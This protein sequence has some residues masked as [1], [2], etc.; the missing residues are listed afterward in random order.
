MSKTLV[1]IHGM[2]GTGRYWSV[3]RALFEV[4]GFTCVAPTLPWHMP[5]EESRRQAVGVG[6]ASLGDYLTYLENCLDAL[7]LE[8]PPILVGH[9]MGGLLSMRLATR[10]PVAALVLLCPAP[11][12]GINAV[13]LDSVRAFLHCL[14]NG[15]FWRKPQRPG[16]ASAVRSTL[17]NLSP[18]KQR[19]YHGRMV[20]E[21][22]RALF[23]IAFPY[24]DSTQG[25]RV[26]RHRLQ[27][28]ILL[29]GGGQDRIVPASVQ[30]R[31]AAW[32]PGTTYREYSENA[33]WLVDEPGTPEIVDD[34]CDWLACAG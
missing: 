10:R 32:L 27:A 28:P 8:A 16:F 13:N 4:R 1:L 30:R 19:E 6:N 18:E 17:N 29:I 23:Q 12:A 20:Y 3:M 7:N 2:W 34:I 31:I 14:A 25:S 22:G 24:L 15:A 26:E 5:D 33:H 9:S 21:S 11:P